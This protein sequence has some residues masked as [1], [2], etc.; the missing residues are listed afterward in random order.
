MTYQCTGSG[1]NDSFRRP[2]LALLLP[3]LLQSLLSL[4]VLVSSEDSRHAHPWTGEIKL[5]AQFDQGVVFP[6]NLHHLHLYLCGAVWRRETVLHFTYIKVDKRNV[7]LEGL[8]ERNQ[9]VLHTCVSGCGIEAQSVCCSLEVLE[10]APSHPSQSH[11][12][13]LYWDWWWTSSPSAS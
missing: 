3:L 1:V 11:S 2:L 5:V 9:P 10:P 13:T 4:A 12:W 6:Q 8:R 7:F